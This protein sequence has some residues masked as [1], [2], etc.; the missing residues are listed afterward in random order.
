[1][2]NQ[3]I[4]SLPSPID[5]RAT[6]RKTSEN[7]EQEAKDIR[8]RR[9]VKGEGQKHSEDFLIF[10]EKRGKINNSRDWRKWFEKKRLPTWS[11][12]RREKIRQHYSG[13]AV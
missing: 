2:T 9:K 11:N 7:F 4:S 3:N 12:S 8:P 1:M 10:R 6:E 13:G 5:R